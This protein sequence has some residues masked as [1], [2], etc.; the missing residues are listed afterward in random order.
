M[1]LEGL[2]IDPGVP[3][4]A[5]VLEEPMPVSDEVPCELYTSGLPKE[6]LD[7]LTTSAPDVTNTE[8]P[9]VPVDSEP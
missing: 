8:V 4:P 7:E 9:P 3:V 1:N 2:P 6:V 5:P